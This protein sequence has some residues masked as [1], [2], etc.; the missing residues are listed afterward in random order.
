MLLAD[1]E[2]VVDGFATL[3]TGL[4]NLWTIMRSALLHITENTYLSI[5]LVS[6]LVYIAFKLIKRA[7]KAARS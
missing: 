6:A 3:G 1:G 4:T 2:T 5:L 7:K